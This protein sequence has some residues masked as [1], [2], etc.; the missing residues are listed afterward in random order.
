MSKSTLSYVVRGALSDV[1][2]DS[3][4]THH[5]AREPVI[6]GVFRGNDANIFGAV[7]PNSVVSEKV[8]DLLDTLAKRLTPLPQ[9]VEETERQVLTDAARSNVGRVHACAAHALGKLEQLLALLEKPEIRRHGADVETMTTDE[10]E[11]VSDP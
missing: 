2:L 1:P 5:S 6:Q 8:V 3:A 11:M 9:I 7:H 10:E 4:A